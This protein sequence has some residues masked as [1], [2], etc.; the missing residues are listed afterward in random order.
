MVCSDLIV[1]FTATKAGVKAEDAVGASVVVIVRTGE[2]GGE[3]CEKFLEAAGGEGLLEEEAW[4]G[5]DIGGVA[6]VGDVGKASSELVL[7]ELAS[8]NVLAWFTGVKNAWRAVRTSGGSG[9]VTHLH[10]L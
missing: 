4:V 3:A 1:G 7:S 2:A 6:A 10:V 9:S 8:E 5:V